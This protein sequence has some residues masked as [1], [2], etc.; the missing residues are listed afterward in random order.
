MRS[1]AQ[2]RCDARAI[3]DAGVAAADP[4]LAVQRHVAVE[5]HKLLIGGRT[6]AGAPSGT[7]PLLASTATLVINNGF[8]AAVPITVLG[9][10]RADID[11]GFAR[12]LVDPS[13]GLTVVTL[14]PFDFNYDSITAFPVPR[15]ATLCGLRVDWQS[16]F[17][18]PGAADG[19]AH[20]G[21]L[22]WT[23]GGLH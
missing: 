12:S 2:L 18:D 21:G 6:Y 10:G 15:D 22:E 1:L 4:S 14:T 7:P 23:L 13:L 3:Y 8:P 20:T 19:L 16:F 17:L 5:D 9:F 11:I